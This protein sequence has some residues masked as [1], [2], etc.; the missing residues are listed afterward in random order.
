MKNTL[1]AFGIIIGGFI[2]L[3]LL[4]TAIVTFPVIVGTVIVVSIVLTLT[5]AL[6]EDLDK[7]DRL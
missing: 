6:K 5:M 3:I 2:V 1:K 7:N 4:V